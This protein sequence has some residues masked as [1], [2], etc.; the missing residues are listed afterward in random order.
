MQKLS[1]K[2]ASNVVAFAD[3]LAVLGGLLMYTMRLS[4][5]ADANRNSGPAQV[6]PGHATRSEAVNNPDP[7]IVRPE[8]PGR[9]TFVPGEPVVPT[10]ERYAAQNGIADDALHTAFSET[11]EGTE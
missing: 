11:R 10:P 2:T 8:T 5:I 6:R 4:S 1:P 9:T 3:P 7:G